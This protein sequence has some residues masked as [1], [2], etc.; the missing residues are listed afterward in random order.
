MTWEITLWYWTGFVFCYSVVL[1]AIAGMHYFIYNHFF[2]TLP[3]LRWGILAHITKKTKSRELTEIHMADGRVFE[4][5][6]KK[7]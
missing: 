2:K 7:K 5:R 1:F 3:A 6:E 4:M